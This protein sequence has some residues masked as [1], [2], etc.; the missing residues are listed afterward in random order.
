MLIKGHPFLSRKK[1]QKEEKN[2][3]PCPAGAETRARSAGSTAIILHHRNL[4]V[5]RQLRTCRQSLMRHRSAHAVGQQGKQ[6]T[7]SGKD[8]SHKKKERST[9]P[10]E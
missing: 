2:A 7:G 6:F 9:S 5:I 8:S 3:Q 4:H 1:G 10:H